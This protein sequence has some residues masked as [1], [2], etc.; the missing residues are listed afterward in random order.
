MEELEPLWRTPEAAAARGY[1]CVSD[2]QSSP[3]VFSRLCTWQTCYQRVSGRA[4]VLATA[5]QSSLLIVLCLLRCLSRG[6]SCCH[7]WQSCINLVPATKSP[8]RV[9]GSLCKAGAMVGLR[10]LA[11]QYAGNICIVL[12]VL[13]ESPE[14]SPVAPLSDRGVSL[15]DLSPG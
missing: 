4:A 9:S 2:T 3:V 6:G 7:T 13:C 10:L 8:R 5:S 14:S 1:A 11:A 12:E 15:C